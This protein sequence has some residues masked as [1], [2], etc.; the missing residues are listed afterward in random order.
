MAKD[1]TAYVCDNCGQES[2]KWIGKC[3]SC[4]QWNT[5]REIRIAGDSG[6]QSARAAAKEVSVARRTGAMGGGIASAA[7]RNTRSGALRLGDISTKDEP[8]MNM[9]DSEL[10]RV[11]GGGLVPGSIVLLGG[12]P[13]IGKST[14]TLPDHNEDGT[15]GGS[16]CE[17]RGKCPPAAHE[18][19]QNRG[20]KERQSVDIVRDFHR[21]GVRPDKGVRT[22][23]YHC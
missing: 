19:G 13:G 7:R 23:T 14:L 11:L 20:R 5:F 6:Q 22:G 3:P 10:N 12:D 21:K 16:V 4:N 17:R 15:D 2:A 1:K 18:G 9:N 8:R